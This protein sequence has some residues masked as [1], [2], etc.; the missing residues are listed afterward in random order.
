MKKIVF[1]AAAAIVLVC[2]PTRARAQQCQDIDGIEEC[3]QT[4]ASDNNVGCFTFDPC[5]LTPPANHA[6]MCGD[7]GTM[8]DF[9]NNLVDVVCPSTCPN[10]QQC[11]GF[12]WGPDGTGQYNGYCFETCGQAGVQCGGIAAING[13]EN[14]GGTLAC[15]IAPTGCNPADPT[16]GTCDGTCPASNETCQ[17]GQCIGPPPPPAPAL[18][19]FALAPFAGVLGI[20]G[21]R[22]RR[23]GR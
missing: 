1:A 10:G 6:P 23:R 3:C 16:A 13:T 7:L 20:V 14:F 22:A 2:L 9:E 19:L 8:R 18:P 17:S 12:V 15:G 5:G 4:W 11:G 21:A